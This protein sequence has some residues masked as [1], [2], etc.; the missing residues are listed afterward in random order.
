[1]Q[2]GAFAVSGALQG[3]GHAAALQISSAVGS[4]LTSLGTGASNASYM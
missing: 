1:M 3:E 2:L 4:E